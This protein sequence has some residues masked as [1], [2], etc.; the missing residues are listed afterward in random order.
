MTRTQLQLDNDTYQVLRHRA[1]AERKSMSAVAR[2]ALRKGLGL[3]EPA[4]SRK[5]ANLTFV[6]FG[7][8]GRRDISIRHDEALDEDFR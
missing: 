2:E 6:S 8:S 5:G 1:Y 3:D 4:Q 7:A